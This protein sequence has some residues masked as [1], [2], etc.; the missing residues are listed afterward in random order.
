[1]KIFER[2]QDAPSRKIIEIT[3]N[4]CGF[5]KNYGRVD[6]IFAARQIIDSEK[7]REKNQG[8]HLAFLDLE[9][10]FLSILSDFRP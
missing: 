3:I 6:G 7:R 9:I 1:M 10:S 4:Q 5:V 2:I 8:V